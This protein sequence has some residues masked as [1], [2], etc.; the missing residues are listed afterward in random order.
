MRRLVNVQEEN[1]AELQ[2]LADEHD[3]ALLAFMGS[4]LSPGPEYAQISMVDEFGI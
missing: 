4:Y 1:S 3:T 2:K